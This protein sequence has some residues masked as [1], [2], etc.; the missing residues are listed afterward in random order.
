MILTLNYFH[1][2]YIKDIRQ[3]PKH[4]SATYLM[5][6]VYRKSNSTSEIIKNGISYYCTFSDERK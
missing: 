5:E 1:K 4:I 3:V 6:L 2:K